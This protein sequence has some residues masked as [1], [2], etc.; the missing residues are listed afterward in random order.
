MTTMIQKLNASIAHIPLP[1]YM[2]HLPISPTGFPIPWF[3]A[4]KKDGTYDIR[5]ADGSKVPRAIRQKLCW[6]CGNTLGRGLAFVIGPMCAVNRITSEPPCHP[7]CAEY[8]VAACPFLTKPRMRRN[9]KDRPDEA[10]DAAGIPLDRNPG[11][12]LIW[13]TTTYTPFHPHAG[14]PGILFKLGKPISLKFYAEGRLATREEILHSIETG[15][16]L[17]RREAEVD[18][19]AAIDAL[20]L[21]YREAMQLLPAA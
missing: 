18:G 15:I 20:E 14:N 5:I 12:A 4:K 17:L 1:H 19:P 7:A 16:P 10:K 13:L 2:R 21:K 3:V 8:A 9:E 6:L 11:V